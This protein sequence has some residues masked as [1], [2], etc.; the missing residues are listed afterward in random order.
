MT[1][2]L[3]ILRAHR[4][5]DDILY[6]LAE[7][8]LARC[9]GDATAA[10]DALWA[11][12]AA[13][14]RACTAELYGHVDCAILSF[15]RAQIRKQRKMIERY[16]EEE[17][18]VPLLVAYI[19]IARM[20]EEAAALGGGGGAPRAPPLAKTTPCCV[21]C[22]S[23]TTSRARSGARGGTRGHERTRVAGKSDE[24]VRFCLGVPGRAVGDRLRRERARAGQGTPVHDRARPGHASARPVRRQCSA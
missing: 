18:G 17:D 13:Q 11:A 15:F 22:R 4:L 3:E 7:N 6:T 8:A 2:L 10:T 12:T 23:S 1:T 16:G 24:A 21:D 9:G 20:L 19:I 14:R 5:E